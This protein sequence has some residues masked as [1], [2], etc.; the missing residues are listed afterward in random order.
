MSRTPSCVNGAQQRLTLPFMSPLIHQPPPP[1]HSP[2]SCHSRC[3]SFGAE[4]VDIAFLNISPSLPGYWDAAVAAIA[5][6][7]CPTPVVPSLSFSISDMGGIWIIYTIFVAGGALALGAT[8]LRD[9]MWGK[10]SGASDI[11]AC[12]E[13]C[14]QAIAVN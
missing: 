13:C 3:T 4:L 10:P 12:M 7:T 6:T 14:R 8:Y 1:T 5:T 9:R 2:T 11:G